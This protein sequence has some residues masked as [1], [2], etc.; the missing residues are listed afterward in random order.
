MGRLQDKVCVITGAGSGIGRASAELFAREGACVVVADIRAEAARPV[1]D[2]IVG[3]GGRATSLT[4]DVGEEE[5]LRDMI[6][7]TIGRYGRIDVLFNNALMTNPDLALR[8]QDLL[9]YDPR[10]LYATM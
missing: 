1:V 6:Q 2:G 4:I 3:A 8:D 7:T 5:Q 9:S 10:V